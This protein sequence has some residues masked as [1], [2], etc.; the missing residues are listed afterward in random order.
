[1]IIQEIQD[2]V[3]FLLLVSDNAYGVL[4]IQ[5]QRFFA[6]DWVAP[7]ERMYGGDAPA[8]DVARASPISGNLDWVDGGL[9]L[10]EGLEI[11]DE[12]W[13]EPFQNLYA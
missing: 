12:F 11:D 9:D 13:R 1:M 7:D 5:E 2:Q 10:A 4:R 6:C 8:S 3:A